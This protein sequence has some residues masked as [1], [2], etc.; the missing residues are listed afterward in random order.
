MKAFVVRDLLPESLFPTINRLH[1]NHRLIMP[2]LLL[3]RFFRFRDAYS[4]ATFYG[5]RPPRFVF[6]SISRFGTWCRDGIL[7][8]L[9][10]K[11][12]SGNTFTKEIFKIFLCKFVD[13]YMMYVEFIFFVRQGIKWSIFD[14]FV[15]WCRLE[16]LASFLLIY[17]FFLIKLKK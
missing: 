16:N 8:V 3:I 9:C 5:S 15:L 12:F 1:H 14:I 13:F 10:K 2:P 4:W 17:N 6:S 11:N 7:A